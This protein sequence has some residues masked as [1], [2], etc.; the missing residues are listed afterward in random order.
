MPAT[1]ATSFLLQGTVSTGTSGYIRLVGKGPATRYVE[2]LATANADTA[3][4]PF[5]V[6]SIA[7]YLVEVATELHF[8]DYSL[9]GTPPVTIPITPV[10]PGGPAPSGFEGSDGTVLT[11]N[12]T[13]G[14][15]T[16]FSGKAKNGSTYSLTV[17]T[18]SSSGGDVQTALKPWVAAKVSLAKDADAPLEFGLAYSPLNRQFG[19]FVARANVSLGV[20]TNLQPLVVEANGS[21]AGLAALSRDIAYYEDSYGAQP[22]SMAAG[23]KD[24]E[25][26]LPITAAFWPFT[27]RFGFFAEALRTIASQTADQLAAPAEAP[28]NVLASLQY[29]PALTSQQFVQA[30]IASVG[31]AI[32]PF[33]AEFVPPTDTGA[34]PWLDA[35][36]WL[37]WVLMKGTGNVV[38]TTAL[39]A[40]YTYFKSLPP[41]S[42]GGSTKIPVYKPPSQQLS[43]ASQIAGLFGSK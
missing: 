39:T 19:V 36:R 42:T 24:P 34:Q 37:G 28:I 25:M 4:G 27:E 15:V 17:E 1:P 8:S 40:E 33:A 21:F 18:V 43:P 7:T 3:L 9:P 16:G 10:H 29:N 30:A 12:R 32:G 11:V 26:Y 6:G 13:S 35:A 2:F 14:Q 41:P 38:L 31:P 5:P 22:S 20:A 23:S